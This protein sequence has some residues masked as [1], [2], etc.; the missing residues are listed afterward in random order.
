MAKMKIKSIAPWFGG[1]RILAAKIIEEL[2]PHKAYWEPFCGSMAVLLCKKPAY[3]ETVCDLH[4]DLINLVRT[5]ADPTHGPAIYRRLR[6]VLFHEDLR[7]EAQAE[8]EKPFAETPE[9][10][11]WYLLHSWVGRNGFAGT[12]GAGK[13][14][15]SVRWTAN[16]GNPAV[17]LTSVVES[18][19]AWRRRLRRVT[20]LRRDA[21]EVLP[22]ID[23][24]DDAAIYADPPYFSK[25]SQYAHDFAPEDHARLAD[26]LCRFKHAR[27]VV[28][29]YDDRGLK[30]LYPGWTKRHLDVHKGLSL[31]NAR[32]ASKTRAPEILLINGPSFAE[33][34]TPL[35]A[36]VA[37]DG[38]PSKPI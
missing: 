23:D 5:V 27:V 26:L 17:R 30:D 35:F 25:S 20:V 16:G 36:G 21:F 24:Q 11:F 10:A 37:T 34:D 19:P 38:K 31:A 8:L 14:T 32:G 18:I 12:A 6:R 22:K 29:Y 2:G 1:K 33:P 15:F 3:L 28:S 13:T 9:R 4:G 7:A